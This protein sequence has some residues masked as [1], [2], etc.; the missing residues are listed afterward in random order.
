MNANRYVV[1]IQKCVL[2]VHFSVT[3]FY[4]KKNQ[5]RSF[6][7]SSVIIAFAGPQQRTV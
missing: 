5:S 3:V 7:S 4:I 1:Y 2:H 6:A